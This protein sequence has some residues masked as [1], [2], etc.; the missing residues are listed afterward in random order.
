MQFEIYTIAVK[1]KRD[2]GEA[3]H[4]RGAGFHDLALPAFLLGVV[5][6]HLKQV[7]GE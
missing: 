3:T 2:F 4:I 6:V 1:P 7:M 5:L